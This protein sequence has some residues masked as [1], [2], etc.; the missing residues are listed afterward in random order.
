[1]KVFLNPEG[2]GGIVLANERVIVG[3]DVPDELIL[4]VAELD[5]GGD[6]GVDWLSTEGVVVS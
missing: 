2:A 5:D 4:A 3:L 6:V 1:M